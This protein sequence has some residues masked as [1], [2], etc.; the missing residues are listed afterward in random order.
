MYR[1]VYTL[2]YLPPLSFVMDNTYSAPAQQSFAKIYAANLSM[3]E[4]LLD[5]FSDDRGDGLGTLL[6]QFISTDRV[7]ETTTHSL[8]RIA[9]RHP[10]LR[11]Y[12]AYRYIE[13]FHYLPTSSRDSF[14][15]DNNL[16]RTTIPNAPLH[17][18][19]QFWRSGVKNTRCYAEQLFLPDY[20]RRG[21]Y[22]A[23]ST[24]VSNAPLNQSI[25]N[26]LLKNLVY[27]SKSDLQVLQRDYKLLKLGKFL[28]E[29]DRNA[30]LHDHM[31]ECKSLYIL[32][33]MQF[34]LRLSP[35]AIEKFLSY[36]GFSIQ[37]LKSDFVCYG[38]ALQPISSATL[39]WMISVCGYEK[40]LKKIY[41]YPQN[42][43]AVD[44]I[45]E[46]T[47]RLPDSRYHKSLLK[48]LRLLIAEVTVEP[49]AVRRARQLL[50][51]YL[52]YA[53]WIKN[54]KLSIGYRIEIY[55]QLLEMLELSLQKNGSDNRNR[56]LYDVLTDY[57]FYILLTFGPFVQENRRYHNPRSYREPKQAYGHYDDRRFKHFFSS[58][59]PIPLKILGQLSVFEP[60][61]AT[62]PV[63]VSVWLSMFR[64]HR[65]ETKPFV[66]K[67]IDHLSNP[68]T[69]WVDAQSDMTERDCDEENR[70]RDSKLRLFYHNLVYYALR[71]RLEIRSPYVYFAYLASQG[72]GYRIKDWYRPREP[73]DHMSCVDDN[74]LVS[75]DNLEKYRLSSYRHDVEISSEIVAHLRGF[76]DL[77]EDIL[78]FFRHPTPHVTNYNTLGFLVYALASNECLCLN[79]LYQRML[80]VKPAWYQQFVLVSILTALF[81][82]GYFHDRIDFRGWV[83][84]HEHSKWR[85]RLSMLSPPLD[86]IVNLFLGPEFTTRRRR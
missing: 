15:R 4:C 83:Y 23:Y 18:M 72:E 8:H 68:S 86:D 19:D 32:S 59:M 54:P 53:S 20:F 52:V 75:R 73:D 21:I 76:D 84:T 27:T 24:I 40:V 1:T 14:F 38:Y 64:N 77:S 34:I 44:S 74:G 5:V 85:T 11:Y 63:D 65:R 41:E 10:K 39:Q 51:K 47:D 67:L 43:V 46:I 57:K 33:I 50:K 70:Y 56:L 71:L 80:G 17:V 26:I 45:T 22:A 55:L 3:Y 2:Y 58:N 9:S 60:L 48:V 35:E 36:L 31:S 49:D 30:L 25:F 6:L 66:D 16:I 7:R 62:N 78:S 13:C 42:P 69:T 61:Y 37:A 79:R 29:N 82:I 12:F 28:E 81:R